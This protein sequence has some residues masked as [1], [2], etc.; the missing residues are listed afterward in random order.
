MARLRL[1]HWKAAEGRER[2]K[3]LRAA[4]FRVDYDEDAPAALAGAKDD[5]PDAF[6]IDLT[7]LPSHGREM[8]WALRQSKKTRAAPLVFV[9]RF[10]DLRTRRR[11]VGDLLRQAAREG[12]IDSRDED[13]Q[14]AGPHSCRSAVIGFICAARRAG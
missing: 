1:V 11:L 2:A 3:E 12:L 7:R 13:G 6:V 8:A 9:G 10:Q 14:R 5:P 4:G